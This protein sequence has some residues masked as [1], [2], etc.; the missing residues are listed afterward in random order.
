MFCQILELAENHKRTTTT[1]NVCDPSTIL[2]LKNQAWMRASSCLKRCH[3]GEGFNLPTIAHQVE[4]WHWIQRISHSVLLGEASL[5][6]TSSCMERAWQ[7][8][9]AAARMQICA[10]LA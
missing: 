4:E 8:A 6:V 3:V 10:Y 5:G 1:A 2:V 7:V 9:A